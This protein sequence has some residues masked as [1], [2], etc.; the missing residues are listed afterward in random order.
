MDNEDGDFPVT[1]LAGLRIE[2][3]IESEL[4]QQLQKARILMD[5]V[6]TFTTHNNNR[7]RQTKTECAHFMTE[8]RIDTQAIQKIAELERSKQPAAFARL[9]QSNLPYLQEVW[10][11]AKRE[12]GVTRFKQHG[13][14]V[15]I[16][17]E[18]G[19]KWVKVST[20]NEKRLLMEM[21][22]KGW[23]WHQSEDSDDE[24]ADSEDSK[25][26]DLDI[27][28]LKTASKLIETSKSKYVQYKHPRI[29]MV[30]TRIRT[31][32]V[33]DIDLLLDMIRSKGITV[34][35]S[36]DLSPVLPLASVLDR[37]TYDPFEHLSDTLNLDCTVLLALVSDI[38]HEQV[39]PQE[40][41]VFL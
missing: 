26:G 17:A 29:V 30:L 7:D 4:N 14:I 19:Q 9:R 18:G 6:T 25:D 23:D 20:I 13:A 24:M 22:I 1:E 16:V 41:Q 15:D 12:K 11:A 8:I 33:T 32:A 37:M 2:N 35:G 38:S 34:L 39:A 31:G 10:N 28:L 27:S 40:W 3:D 36:N 5:E 21:T